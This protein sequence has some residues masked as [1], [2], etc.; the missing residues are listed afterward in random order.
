M[1]NGGECKSAFVHCKHVTGE[2]GFA[3]R[4]KESSTIKHSLRL[5]Y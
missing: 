2:T 4:R 3:Q 1:I 5:A